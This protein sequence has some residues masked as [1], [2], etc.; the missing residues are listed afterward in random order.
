MS[1]LPK[2]GICM[3]EC[4][5]VFIGMPDGVHCTRCGLK[6]TPAEYAAMVNTPKP[7]AKKP[8]RAGKKVTKDE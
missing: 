5:H 8:M 3:T 7:E 2:E 1:I 6:M 4:K